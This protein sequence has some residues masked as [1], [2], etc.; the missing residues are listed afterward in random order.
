MAL[1]YPNPS[2]LKKAQLKQQSLYNGNLLLEEHDPPAVYDSEETLELAQES[3]EK[4]RF[5]KKEI[6]PANYA[7]INHLSGVF[8]PQKT[9]SKEELFLSNVS[10]MVTVPKRFLYQMKIFQMTLLQVLHEIKFVRDF[11]SLAKEA[12]ESLDKKKYLELEIERLLKA[13]VS[14]DIMSIMQNGFVDVSSDLQ[15]ELDRLVYTARTRR[16]QPTGNTRNVRAPSASKSSEVKKNVTI[17]DHHRTLLLSKNQKT[18]SSKCNNIKLAIR[19]DKSKIVCGTN[20]KTFSKFNCVSWQVV[21]ICLWC[22]DSGCCKHMT[23]NIKLLINFVWK[24]LGTVRFG[25]DYI[26]AIFGYSDLKW[27]NITITREEHFFIRDLDGVD[28]IKGNCFTNLYTINL[29][30]MTSASPI[31]LMACATPTKSWL[32]HQRLSHLNFDTINDLAKNDIVSSL[33]KFK[34]AKEH[35][36]PSCEQEKSKRASYPPKPVP[37]SKL[38]LHLLH[39][40]LIG[41][42][43][44][45]SI[46]GKRNRTLVEAARTML[47]FS[48]A[49]LFLWAKAIATTCYTQNRSIIHRCFNKTPYELIQ[50][51]KPGISYLHVFGALCYPNNDRED[52]GILGAK[53]DIGFFIGYS[54]NSVAYRVYNHRTK[55]IM[56]TMNVTF[57]ELSAMAFEQKSSRPGLQSMTSGQI[58]SE[59]ELT[60]A[61]SKITPQRPSE[62]DLDI[63]FKPLHNEYLDGRPSKAP[64]T[65]PAAPMLQNLQ[66]PTASK[67][68]N[69]TSS[70]TASAA[71][72]VLNAVFEGD[73]FVNP[74]ATPSTESV[75]SSTQY[76]DPSYIIMKPKTVKESL[77]D[78]AWIESMQEELHQFIRLDVWELVPSPDGIKPLTLKW[79][80]KNKHD[81][82]NT[83]IRNKTRL[84]VRGYRQEEGIDFEESI[85]PV[86]QMEAIRIFLA[87][88]AHKGFT[89]YQMDV[90][91]AFLH[92]SLK[93][94]VY[95]CQPEGFIDADHPS[96]VCK[97]K[98]ALY[99]LKQA[100]RAWYDALSTFLLQNGFSKGITDLTLFTRRF[101]DDILVVQVYVDDIIFGSTDPRYA[102]LFSDL[103]KSRFKMS[104]M[105]EMTF[106]LGLQV[107]QS[108]SGI[109]I[110]QSNYVNEI[111]KKYGLNTC[112]IIGTPMDIKDKLDL[113]QIGT[114]V[115]ATKYRSMIADPRV[116]LILGRSFLRTGRAL[117]DV[118]EEEIT[119]RYN[120]KS[121]N[122]TLVSDPSI[123]E[124]DFSK[125][126]I[127]KSSSLTLTPFRESDFFLEEIEDF[128]NDDLIPTGIENSMYDP[129]EDILF[130]E[131]LLNEDPF[132]LPPMDL[133]LAEETK[134]KSSV[135]KPPELELK[136]LPSHLEYAFLE[137]SNKLPVIIA[138]D[139]KDVE[140]EA[141]IKILKSHKRA[142]SWKIFDIKGIDLRFCTHKILIEEDYKPP[143][144]SQTRVNPKIHDIIKTKVIKLLDA[145][146]IYPISDSP[147]VSPIHCVPK[148]GGITVVA[149]ENN[150][151]IPTTLVT[152]WRVCIDYRK[153]NDATRKDHF[154]LPFMDQML[155]RLAGNEF[156]CFLDGFSR[157]FQI[158]IDPQDQ[159]KTTFTCPYGTF[160]YR[161][162]PFGLEWIVLGH[163]ISKSSIEVDRAKVDVIAKLPHP[164]AVKDFMGPFPSS[165]GNKYILVAFDYLSKCV[166]AKAL[167]TN[168]ARV[169]VKFLKSL[170]SR[171]GIP[172]AIISD[173]GIHFCNDQFTRVMIKAYWALK[174]VNF[175]LKTASDH[176][177]LQLNELSELHDQAYENFII[178]KERTKK[179]HDSKI[180]N[181]I[182]NVGFSYGTIELSQPNGPNFKVNGH[183]VK[184]YFGGDIPSNVVSDLHIEWIVLGHKI[185][186]SSIEVDRAIVDVIA[187]LPHPTTVKDFMGPF[188]SSK[189]N[190]YILVAV[191]YLSKCVEA[192]AL[193]TNDVRVVVKFLKSLFSRFGIPKAIIS[194]HGTHFCNDQFTKVMIKYGVTHRLATAYHPQMSGQVKLSNRGLK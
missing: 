12:D 153:L 36:C 93:E 29:Y 17:E 21:Q 135:E 73:L 88:A 89:V 1:G 157:Y 15:T 117:I 10:N 70:P 87:Y 120:P 154:S 112:D 148:K 180:N 13:S 173:H 159:E 121:S 27:G 145:G 186:K 177:K 142:I 39:M 6:K 71:D 162:M 84:V 127:V 96:H 32:W 34:Y 37:N 94:Y 46:N 59:L 141:L 4:M 55:I 102:T 57:D 146:M 48:H 113:D 193:P 62:R 20:E 105:G 38:W 63:L 109:F 161:R 24:F 92:G 182:F 16:P 7:K 158:P 134:A 190:K 79:L 53:G 167:P 76:V 118:Y 165:K 26:A 156:Y 41:P 42:M 40:D 129:E 44:V 60:Y 2:Y 9:K 124:S 188:P 114:P 78:L 110:N 11:K 98:K 174:H 5:L 25:N 33:P 19:N 106:F 181:R 81:E 133:K 149:N 101:D 160:A 65:I 30:D 56:E 150:E 49:S 80:L 123:S 191:D 23:E 95:V 130:L 125:E 14:H 103:M 83:V 147:W 164:T 3:R 184:H 51:R 28:L 144:Q 43:R 131:K 64:R 140:K 132:Q 82:E 97:L 136:E 104:M 58:S 116:P 111:L 122:P 170:F 61:P 67:Q 91:T 107:K 50:G 85:A 119:L 172:K 194:D 72:N 90:K 54:A 192:K 99:G 169:V 175:D 152:G 189:G 75:V 8:V 22:V 45:A 68:K 74:F 166:E 69:L 108:P 155:E 183:C 126:L 185:S 168:D 179:L 35:L 128:L 86:A 115:D 77:T 139:L 66:A 137:E 52:I 143:V 187:K 178:Y 171:F 100:P 163:K 138:K 18:M 176:R 151:L 47:I 31:C